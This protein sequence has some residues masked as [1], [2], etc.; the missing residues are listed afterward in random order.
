MICVIHIWRKIKIKKCFNIKIILIYFSSTNWSIIFLSYVARQVYLNRLFFNMNKNIKNTFYMYK[1]YAKIWTAHHLG[2][3]RLASV[4]F[5]STRLSTRL[6]PR[7]TLVHITS[8]HSH[9]H[10][11]SYSHSHS[12]SHSHLILPSTL[13]YLTLPHP[14]SSHLVSPRLALASL[15]LASSLVSFRAASRVRVASVGSRQYKLKIRVR[16]PSAMWCAPR[17]EIFEIVNRKLLS[18]LYSRYDCAG[19]CRSYIQA[20]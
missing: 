4:R 8:P 10:S 19:V 3:L 9:S 15:N 7:P 13:S 11:H 18:L 20:L 5:D 17:V 6:A 1:V 14:A 12:H 16:R 2:S